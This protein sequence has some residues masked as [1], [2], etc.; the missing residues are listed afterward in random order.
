MLARS[1]LSSIKSKIS[2][3]LINNQISREDFLTIVNEE[4][5]YREFKESIRMTKGQKDK[6]N[7]Y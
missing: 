2:E 6:K 1:K 7:R 5:H 4:R 3:T